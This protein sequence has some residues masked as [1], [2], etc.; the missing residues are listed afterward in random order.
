MT[1]SPIEAICRRNRA[2]PYDWTDA[3]YGHLELRHQKSTRCAGAEIRGACRFAVCLG[4]D[5]GGVA[6]WRRESEPPRARCAR[7]VIPR[8]TRD[9]RLDRPRIHTLREAALRSRTNG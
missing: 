3:R 9:S 7:R 1:S 5:C 6:V 8:T 4:H 2:T